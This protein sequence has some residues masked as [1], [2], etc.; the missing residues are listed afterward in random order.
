[1]IARRYV[2]EENGK[3]GALQWVFITRIVLFD[4]TGLVHRKEEV[5][6]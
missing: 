3:R 2:I 4:K 1:M 6:I 5:S